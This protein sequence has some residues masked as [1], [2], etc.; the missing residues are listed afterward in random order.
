[1]LRSKVLTKLIPEASDWKVPLSLLSDPKSLPRGP[2]SLMG[3]MLFSLPPKNAVT[4]M[5]L[6]FLSRAATLKPFITGFMLLR[7]NDDS[8]ASPGRTVLSVCTWCI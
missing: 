8:M 2:V 1:M 5:K 6:L 7:W 3:L 4:S